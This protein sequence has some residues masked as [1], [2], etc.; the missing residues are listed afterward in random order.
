MEWYLLVG[1]LVVF[2]IALIIGIRWGTQR[3]RRRLQFP[4]RTATR[5]P[6]DS[7]LSYEDITLTRP[8]GVAIAAWFIPGRTRRT[9]L[10]LHGFAIERSSLLGF[11][12]RFHAHGYTLCLPDLRGHGASSPAVCTFG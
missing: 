10:L 9:L 11:A 4:H 2:T 7:G 6:A 5:T 1:G 12:A 3:V 8:D